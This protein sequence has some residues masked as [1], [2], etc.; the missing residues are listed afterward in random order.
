M[1]VLMPKLSSTKLVVVPQ[2]WRMFE[3][4]V[5]ISDGDLSVAGVYREDLPSA[6][7]NPFKAVK[8]VKKFGLDEL[9]NEVD[10]NI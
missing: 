3:S 2:L 9:V 5:Y 4:Q 10:L 8:N 6:I 7:F 1:S